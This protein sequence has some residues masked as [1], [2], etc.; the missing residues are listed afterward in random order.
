MHTDGKTTEDAEPYSNAYVTE[1]DVEESRPIRGEWF[2]GF[3]V[4]M[5]HHST[6]D[7]VILLWRKKRPVDEINGSFVFIEETF[8]SGRDCNS[9]SIAARELV[10]WL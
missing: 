1:M 3:N 8:R 5:R 4:K 7:A 9:N 2:L 6:S 10:Y